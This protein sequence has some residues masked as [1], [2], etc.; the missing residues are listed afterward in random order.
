MKLLMLH[1]ATTCFYCS[2]AGS[3]IAQE[4]VFTG[5]KSNMKKAEFYFENRSYGDAAELFEREIEKRPENNS[6][7]LKLASSYFFNND[8][9]NAVYWYREYES[10]GGTFEPENE[11]YY[12]TALHS[13]GLYK[14]AIPRLD[15]YKSSESVAEDFSEKIWQ[16]QNIHYLMEDSIFYVI[17]SIDCNTTDDEIAPALLGNKLIF[18][19]NRKK[20][21][22]I[23]RVDASTGKSYFSWYKRYLDG[24]VDST[25]EKKNKK[26]VI[27][28]APEIK[29]K[30][31]KAGMSFSDDGTTMVYA[32]VTESSDGHQHSSKL[33][34]GKRMGKKW[35][36]T[37][38]FPYNSTQYSLTNPSLAAQGT[39]LYFTS[40]MP[41]GVGGTDIYFSQLLDNAWSKPVNMGSGINTSKNE[42]HPFAYGERLYFSS[43]GHP[44]LGGLDIFH[45][46][47]NEKP[48]KIVNH[49]YPANTYHDDF[50]LILDITG[51]EGYLCSNRDQYKDQGDDVYKIE[52]KKLS[53]PLNVNGIISFKKYD[54]KDGR[55]ILT[56][57]SNASIELIDKLSNEVVQVS[58][59]DNFG[60]FSINIPY[61]SKFLL[62]VTQN[63]LGTAVVSMEIPKNHRDYLNHD[64]VI[65][66]DLFNSSDIKEFPRENKLYGNE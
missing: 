41:G 62:K 64:I 1:I 49:G 15:K 33:F 3:L 7:R 20:F 46:E 60:N 59:T 53:F 25:I 65:V 57:L 26:A 22:L 45:V 47:L 6:I 43:D 50:G 39:K 55:M 38:P 27:T 66:Q 36:E 61:E 58:T 34:F 63:K 52:Y 42:G 56:K 13:S 14:E 35:V 19:S 23:K 9:R 17:K 8:M 48:F 31:H 2:I 44:G 21:S 11:L 51:S 12:A 4:S 28:F 10:N 54:M 32:K 40:D 5:L 18:S 37:E 16:L 30:F 29:S 24:T